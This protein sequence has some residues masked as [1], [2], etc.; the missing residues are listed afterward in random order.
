MSYGDPTAG[1]HAAFAVI[2]A[3]YYRDRTGKGQYIDMSQ[4]ESSMVVLGDAFM[5]QVMNGA[6]PERDGSHDPNMSP[7]NVYRC[8]GEDR[9]V[10][11]A[12]RNDDE[13]R[14]LCG[15]IGK[16]ELADDPRFMTLADRKANEDALDAE[17]EA[18]TS[19]QE[20]FAATEAL[21]AA[22]VPAYPPLMN[23]E[24]MASEQIAAHSFWVEK[25]HPVAGVRRHAGIPWRLS[26]TPLEVWRAAPVMGQDNEYVFGE[27]LG[28]SSDQIADLVA[29][30]VIK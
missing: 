25:E 4:W 17:V 5:H 19:Q 21:Q 9:W 28:M 3:L 18:W 20:P 24:V 26:E 15:V 8:A 22:G 12:V 1:L 10:S 7:H 16:P 30:E 14:A 23:S 13:F 11:L 27:L 6:P 29:R 2:A